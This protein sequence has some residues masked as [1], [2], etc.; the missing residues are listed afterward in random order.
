VR[1]ERQEFPLAVV[2]LNATVWALAALRAGRLDGAAARLGGAARAADAFHCG[3]V[4][5]FAESWR[6]GRHSMARSGVVM[7]QLQQHCMRHPRR[8]LRLAGTPAA[9][10][11]ALR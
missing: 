4:Y 9:V 11:A 2:S 7:K 6:S 1:S 10:V 8:V 3:C 5:A